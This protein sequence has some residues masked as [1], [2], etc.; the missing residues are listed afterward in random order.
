MAMSSCM[1]R[2]PGSGAYLLVHA[3]RVELLQREVHAPLARAPQPALL[4]VLPHRHERLALEDTGAGERRVAR[5]AT[6]EPPQSPAKLAGD[7]RHFTAAAV[8]GAVVGGCW[9]RCGAVRCGGG[10]WR[11]RRRRRRSQRRRG[12]CWWPGDVPC[13]WRRRWPGPRYPGTRVRV[14]LGS[15]CRISRSCR[16]RRCRRRSRRLRPDPIL[17]S[18]C[19]R[20][21][22][23]AAQQGRGD[24]VS[25]L[26]QHLHG[27]P[28]VAS[29]AAQTGVAAAVQAQARLAGQPALVG[30]SA[31]AGRHLGYIEVSP[32]TGKLAMTGSLLPH[33]RARRRGSWP[34]V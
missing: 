32:G 23:R 20:R 12:C 8:A 16:G 27:T 9:R 22:V 26:T 24:G 13:L 19:R 30:T 11:W 6:A 29:A 14:L 15:P 4:V 5:P 33:V 21:V 2:R 3:Q 18:G 34:A 17:S 28:A 7:S 31:A 1:H 10:R 25:T